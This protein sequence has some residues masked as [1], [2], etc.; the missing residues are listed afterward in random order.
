MEQRGDLIKKGPGA[1]GAAAV[2]THIR[3]LQL[4]AGA[5]L[6][7]EDDLGVLPAELDGSTH[8]L[9]TRPE[10]DG[11]CHHL[12]YIRQTYRLRQAFGPGA[13]ERKAELP[14]RK[15][16]CQPPDGVGDAFHLVGVVT[17]VIRIGHPPALRLQCDDLGCG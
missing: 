1:A 6:S 15:M 11:V 17:L 7:E 14:V 12:L 4:T 3:C 8:P 5:V 2:H 13:G 10:S 9:I 16:S